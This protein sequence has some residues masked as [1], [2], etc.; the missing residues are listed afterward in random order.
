MPNSFRYN[1]LPTPAFGHRSQE[2]KK[3]NI[4]SCGGCLLI[5]CALLVVSGC[6]RGAEVEQTRPERIVTVEMSQA[7]EREWQMVAHAVG[8][9]TADEQVRVRNEMAGVVRAVEASEGDVVE[10]GDV[11]L[12]IDDERA[13]LDVQ[14]AEARHREMQAN[15]DRRRP[16]F[17]KNLI[18]EAEM[19]QAES[20][21]K[22][23]EAEL[24]LMR[25][26][27][28][29]TVVRA[30]IAGTL[31]RRYI[32]PGDYADM[33]THL[34]DLVKI[35]RLKLDFEL[36]ERYLSLLKVGQ[37]VRVRTAAYP[38]RP[39]TGQVYF[40]DPLINLATR[41]V[42]VRARVDNSEQLLRPNLFVNVAL[43]V[44][45][46]E[47]AVVVPEEAIISDLGDYMIYLCDGNM[48]A[49]IRNV[50][51]GER[52]P[53]WIQIVEGAQP[54]ERVVIAGQQRLQ[55][56]MRMRCRLEEEEE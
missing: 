54:G 3:I 24:G 53:G 27:L 48:R 52:E 40:I 10:K 31:G 33:G 55:P 6:G 43:D 56:G 1:L 35:D 45:L 34:F 38:E 49:E 46:L 39:F 7:I 30:P 32:S 41:T 26:R 44:S 47:N 5:L 4:P 16:L 36:P 14:R 21:F 28:A 15:L 17:E 18:T 51:L 22:A 12:R 11:L 20:D 42:P 50:R 9:L 23:A 13:G 2:G 37:Q 29:D 8:S 25:R 19:I